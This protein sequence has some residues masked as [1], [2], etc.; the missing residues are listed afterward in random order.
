MNSVPGSDEAAPSTWEDIRS[1]RKRTRQVLIE[2]RMS[3][4]AHVRLA[5][6]QVAKQRL[7]EAVDFR[8][9][10][11]LGI[12]WPMRA[13]MDVRD[14]ARRHV[15]AGGVVGLPVVVERAAPVEFWKWQPGAKMQRGIWDI[16][17]PAEREVV[18][19][20]VCIIPLV[21]F[22]ALGYRLG[23]GGGYYDRT[24]AAASP[25]PLCA[26]LGFTDSYLSTIYPQ[27]H[28]I[29]MDIVV[30]ERIVYRANAG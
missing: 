13:E 4:P 11:V 27:P 21:G 28:D 15:E 26:G 19:P 12:Y 23:Y 2:Q 17:I 7:V 1:W 29:P 9:H 16:P 3:A 6:G 22:D 8:A 20:S 30:T 24:L 14:I 18:H 5:R 25:R 10:N